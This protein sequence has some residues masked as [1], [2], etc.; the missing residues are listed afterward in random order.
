MFTQTTNNNIPQNFRT[1]RPLGPLFFNTWVKKSVVVAVLI[2][3]LGL[4]HIVGVKRKRI[5][6]PAFVFLRAMSNVIWK[7]I[8]GNQEPHLPN[9]QKQ[10]PE[11]FFEKRCL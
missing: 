1:L 8:P 7:R 3:D 2:L 6:C 11:M 9:L 10:S 5:F 4:S